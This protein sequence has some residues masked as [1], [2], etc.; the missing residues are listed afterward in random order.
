VP[1]YHDGNIV[2]ALELIFRPLEWLRRAGHSHL[3]TQS[4]GLVTVWQ[5]DDP[6]GV[7]G[8]ALK[9]SMAAERSSMLAAIEKLEA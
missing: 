9:K 1:V 6:S 4:A 8:S 5:N 3:P 7:A 2:G